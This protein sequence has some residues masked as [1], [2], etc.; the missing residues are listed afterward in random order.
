MKDLII[1]RQVY[2]NIL[3]TIGLLEPERG[4]ILGADESGVISHYYYDASAQHSCNSYEPDVDAV[5]NVLLNE[6]HPKGVR[7]VGI[8]HSHANGNSVPSCGDVNYGMRILQSLDDLEHFYLPIV[9]FE[10]HTPQLTSFRVEKDEQA[11]YVCRMTD[12]SVCERK[13][14]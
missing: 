6:W 11:G 10:N 3:H 2:E 12:W 7:M 5:N 14:K 4:G 1:T 9:T 13:E 8:V